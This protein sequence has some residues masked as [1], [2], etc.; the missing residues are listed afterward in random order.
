LSSCLIV[1]VSILFYSNYG[2]FFLTSPAFL[3]SSHYFAAALPLI[4]GLALLHASEDRLTVIFGLHRRWRHPQP[5]LF[6]C[7][8]QQSA[9]YAQPVRYA[10]PSSLTGPFSRLVALFRRSFARSFPV[11][12]LKINTFRTVYPYDQGRG[13]PPFAIPLPRACSHPL[14]P[15]HSGNAARVANLYSVALVIACRRIRLVP[16]IA[17]WEGFS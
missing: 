1:V 3:L 2:R 6:G 5:P 15:S 7:P 14:Q 13:C 8:T 11:N 17:V 4:Q 10:Q 12:R 16:S 9:S